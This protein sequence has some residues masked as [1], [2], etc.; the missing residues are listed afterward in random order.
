MLLYLVLHEHFDVLFLLL[1]E[2]PA[3]V[4]Q[5]LQVA[6]LPLLEVF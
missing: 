4:L 3:V 5:Q 6:V 2:Q 1:Q